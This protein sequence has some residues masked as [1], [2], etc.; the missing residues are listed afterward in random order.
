MEFSIQITELFNLILKISHSTVQGYP[1]ISPLG[2]PG[3][4]AKPTKAFSMTPYSE[5]NLELRDDLHGMVPPP[6]KGAPAADQEL[7]LSF[8]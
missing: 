7:A 8:S 2:H 5:K 1:R 3:V 4:G 6:P